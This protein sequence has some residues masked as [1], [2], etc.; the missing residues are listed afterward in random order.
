MNAV[1]K[2]VLCEFGLARIL[3]EVPSGLTTSTVHMGT[4]RYA[5]PELVNSDNPCH[6]SQSDVWAWGCLLLVVRIPQF[7]LSD[8]DRSIQIIADRQ[9]HEAAK[10]EFN[11]IRSISQGGLPADLRTV[12]SCPEV[13]T[14]LLKCWNI[15][16]ALRPSMEDCLKH[17]GGSTGTTKMTVASRFLDTNQQPDRLFEHDFGSVPQA[18]SPSGPSPSPIPD[19]PPPQ[20]VPVIPRQWVE[21]I[22]YSPRDEVSRSRPQP[23][24][25]PAPYRIMQA[26]G[27]LGKSKKEFRCTWKGCSSVFLKRSAIEQVSAFPLSIGVSNMTLWNVAL[28]LTYIFLTQHI[29]THTGVQRKCSH[30]LQ[31][32]S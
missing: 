23:V 10:L 26:K 18:T 31:G 19:I 25:R 8:A 13:K 3:A 14:V 15:A 1:E 24:S 30:L 22:P 20:A 27:F 17:L 7:S 4:T 28:V 5:S 16:P 2:A 32:R 11:V 21:P 6:T 12:D 9:P 29:L